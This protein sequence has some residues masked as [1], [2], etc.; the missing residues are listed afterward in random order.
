MS[1]VVHLSFLFEQ[2]RIHGRKVV[3]GWARAQM[4]KCHGQMDGRMDVGRMDGWTDGR[5]DGWKERL[6]LQGV[7]SRDQ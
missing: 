7:E 2:G 1:K 5:T 4:H 6:T 3:D